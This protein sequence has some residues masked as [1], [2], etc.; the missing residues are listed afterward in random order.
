MRAGASHPQTL[1]NRADVALRRGLMH[2]AIERM[3]SGQVKA[4]E[5]RIFKLSE[6]R[7]THE[8]L[9]QGLVSGK[10]VMHP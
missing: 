9:D 8:L 7:Q 2:E 3:A 4:P 5:C 6:A 1:Y 10:L